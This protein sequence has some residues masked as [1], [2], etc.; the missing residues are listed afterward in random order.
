MGEDYTLGHRPALDGIRG[1]A[2]LLV[3]VGHAL[4]PTSSDPATAGVTIFFVL[5]GFLITQLLLE[6]RQSTGRVRLGRFYVR[7]ARRLLPALWLL[8]APTVALAAAGKVSWQPV[9]LAATYTTDLAPALGMHAGPLVHLWSLSL[10]EQ[11]YGL[12]P[13]LLVP[14]IRS[15]WRGCLAV[16]GAIVASTVLRHVL[17]HDQASA[18]AHGFRP[19][20]RADAILLGC[21][22]ALT[23]RVWCRWAYLPLAA[24]LSTAVFVVAVTR[25]GW[26]GSADMIIVLALSSAVVVAWAATTSGGP[27]AKALA[28]RPLRFTGRISY[29]MY[30]WQT[31]VVVA[32]LDVP[33][34]KRLA[35]VLVATYAIA[36]TSWYLVERPFLH[37]RR[38]EPTGA[39]DRGASVSISGSR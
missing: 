28:I 2:V 9:V 35:L 34:L 10:E 37:R 30:L 6:E 18:I 12:W 21:L 31:P 29:A 19:D 14:V 25:H 17:V 20:T 3:I 33:P 32:M 23:S 1:V 8:L 15:R 39:L 11:F 26:P 7:R 13:L 38:S 22:L 4:G 36:A 27:A 5:S 24:A 16:A